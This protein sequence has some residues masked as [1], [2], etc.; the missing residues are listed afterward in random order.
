M[1]L[2]NRFYL[3]DANWRL[4]YSDRDQ[5]KTY[6]QK[7]SKWQAHVEERLKVLGQRTG[8]SFLILLVVRRTSENLGRLC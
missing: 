5:V 4:N 1:Y 3:F 2:L 8:T 6:Q 7:I